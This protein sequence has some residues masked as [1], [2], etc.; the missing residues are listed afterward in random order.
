MATTEEEEWHIEV[1]V[2]GMVVVVMEASHLQERIVAVVG[3]V[4]EE[5]GVDVS[6]EGV[7]GA[8]GAITHQ[9]MHNRITKVAV[10][11]TQIQLF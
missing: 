11:L 10:A 5:V 9:R 3:A 2:V 6:F 4:A 8:E 7:E 1:V